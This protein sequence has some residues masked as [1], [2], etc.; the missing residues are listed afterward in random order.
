[1]TLWDGRWIKWWI[2]VTVS[3]SSDCVTATLPEMFLCS[4]T[5]RG[6]EVNSWLSL[7]ERSAFAL[8]RSSAGPKFNSTWQVWPQQ[9]SL[10][11]RG[12]VTPESELFLCFKLN[13]H[14]HFTSSFP[15]RPLVTWHD[16]KSQ[17]PFQ[18]LIDPI[19]RQTVS[20]L[21]HFQNY[22]F[23]SFETLQLWY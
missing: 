15:G 4:V 2:P 1:M 5:R 21:R 9:H 18:I 10:L 17:R 20:G 13:S 7:C 19:V 8:W 16:L 12:I 6:T 22:W 23:T 11:C 14:K 3:Q